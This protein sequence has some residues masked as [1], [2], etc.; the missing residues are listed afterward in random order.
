M[1]LEGR[2]KAIKEALCLSVDQE[3]FA[4]Q[5]PRGVGGKPAPGELSRLASSVSPGVFIPSPENCFCW[6]HLGKGD[7]LGS[8][9]SVL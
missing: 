2:E 7:V 3:S 4:F 9:L 1:S 6:G 5:P 8:S